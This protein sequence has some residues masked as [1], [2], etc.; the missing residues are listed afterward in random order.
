MPGSAA[1]LEDLRCAVERPAGEGISKGNWRW[2]VR[3]QMAGVRDVLMREAPI[4]NA[5]LTAR[6][7]AVMRE[8]N[9]LLSR[10]SALGPVVLETEEVDEVRTQLRRLLADIG[11]HIQRIHDLAYD[12]V[13]LELGGS[14]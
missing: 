9:L 7:G 5:W 4:Q 11:H 2:S 14:E 12:D 6:G 10:L 3:Q 13:E 1:A 8:R